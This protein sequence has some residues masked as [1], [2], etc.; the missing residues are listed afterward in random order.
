MAHNHHSGAAAPGLAAPERLSVAP[1]MAT[2]ADGPA[3]RGD[4]EQQTTESLRQAA[5]DGDERVRDLQR[6]LQLAGFQFHIGD[7]HTRPV[8]WISRWGLTRELDSL[9]EVETFASQVGAK[10]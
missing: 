2:P 8:F 1:Q 4:K 10:P 5:A 7:H 9:A 3:L 6:R